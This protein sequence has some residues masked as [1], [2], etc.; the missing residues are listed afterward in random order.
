MRQ[1]GGQALIRALSAND[2]EKIFCVAGESYLAALD[3]LVDEPQIQVITCRHEGAACFMAEA[4]GKLTG[5][6]GIC[7]VTRGPGACNASIGVHTAKQDS[8][9]LIL[10]IGQVAR[11]DRGREAFQEI[12]FAEMFSNVAKACMRIETAEE[13]TNTV[14]RAF[15]TALEGRRGP[16]V[17]ELPEDM[18][19]EE[20]ECAPL[21]PLAI[22]AQQADPAF[23]KNLAGILEG[24]EKPLIILGGSG[25]SDDD[26]R[27]VQNWAEVHGIP[28]AASFR[29][30][31]LIAHTSPVYV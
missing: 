22:P 5:K 1:T 6:P 28:V 31:D 12:E 29:R 13:V 19:R 11:E 27:R 17:I 10:L 18:L 16:V 3:A 30:Q 4:Y 14:S 23:L 8:T 26:C 21:T 9:P 24:S 7:F 2:V 20:A 15:L 25:W